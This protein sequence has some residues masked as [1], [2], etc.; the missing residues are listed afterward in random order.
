MPAKKIKNKTNIRKNVGIEGYNPNIVIVE[1]K[2]QIEPSYQYRAIRSKNY[3][4]SNWHRNKFFIL[5][6]LLNFNKKMNILD[7]GTGSGN[8]EILFNKKVAKIVGVDY[9]NEAL[10]FLRGY[11]DNHKIRNVDLIQSDIRKLTKFGKL[12]KFEAIVVVDVIEH[13]NKTDS[14]HLVNNLKRFLVR[15][16]KV[17]II[18]PNYKSPWSLIEWMLDRTNF[19]PKFAEAQHLSQYYPEN[20]KQ[21]FIKNGFHVDSVCSFNLFS[22]LFRNHKLSQ[23][24]CKIEIGLPFAFGNL[25]AGVFTVND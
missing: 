17:C 24:L 12:K 1:K 15:G 11:L 2:L 14:S 4:Q 19:V 13:L 8:F 10:M 22:Y 9:N 5:N 20:L 3:L 18:T 21:I 6:R 25:I 23:T 16:G 7:L